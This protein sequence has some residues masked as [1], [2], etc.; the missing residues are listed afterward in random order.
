MLKHSKIGVRLFLLFLLTAVVPVIS[1]IIYFGSELEKISLQQ[2]EKQLVFDAKNFSEAILNKLKSADTSLYQLE[3]ELIARGLSN[4]DLNTIREIFSAISISRDQK[5]LAVFYGDAISFS[6]LKIKT[7]GTRITSFS[8]NGVEHIALIHANTTN[9]IT[10]VGIIN[11]NFLWLNEVANDNTNYTIYG[12]GQRLATLARDDQ[13]GEVMLLN[14]SSPTKVKRSIKSNVDSMSRSRDIN[15]SSLFD[16]EPW[17]VTATLGN[18]HNTIASAKS[19]QALTIITFSILLLV[20]LISSRQIR[21]IVSPLEKLTSATQRLGTNNSHEPLIIDS[22]D[23]IGQLAQSFNKMSEKLVKQFRTLEGLSIIDE[24]ILT[25]ENIRNTS[26]LILREICEIFNCQQSMLLIIPENKNESAQT[27][28]YDTSVAGVAKHR[29]QKSTALEDHTLP[30]DSNTTYYRNGTEFP[31]IFK[32][33]S[34][35]GVNQLLVSPVVSDSKLIA[36]IAAGFASQQDDIESLISSLE[37]FSRRVGVA[38]RSTQDSQK[39]YHRANY[40]SLTGLS[41]RAHFIEQLNAIIQ[42]ANAE[43][44]SLA[45]MFIDLDRFKHVNDVQ[46]HE[47]GDKL[48]KHVAEKL[49]KATNDDSIVARFG[50]D[51]FLILMPETSSQKYV[52]IM[53][54]AL[55]NDLSQPITID[56]HEHFIDSSIGIAMYP[57]HGK[58]AEILIKNTDIAMYLAKQAGGGNYRVFN[59]QMNANAMKRVALESALYHAIER[60]ELFLVYQPKMCIKK[61]R[62]CGAEALIRWQHPIHG[63]IPPDQFVAIAEETG[64][65]LPIGTWIYRSIIKQIASW[66]KQGLT[67]DHIAINISVR[68][69]KSEGF[70]EKLRMCLEEHKVEPKYIDIEITETMFID[71]MENSIKVL[72]QLHE[73]GVSISID[74]FG[75]GYSSLNYLSQLPFDTLKIDRS[76]LEKVNQDKNAASLTSAIIA[77]AHS[78]DKNVVAEGVE[79]LE[80]LQFLR[81]RDCDYAQG[82]Y[83]AKPLSSSDFEHYSKAHAEKTDISAHALNH[84]QQ[85]Q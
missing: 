17:Q 5:K 56:F 7:V 47:A 16:A 21:K 66:L 62:I 75:T 45:L 83:Y 27:L 71:D 58:S 72:E 28:R 60:D 13:S 80:Q 41:N 30:S 61:D 2:F 12:N 50:G 77:L 25:G 11:P 34:E 67:L 37:N 64:Q 53:A 24:S 44:T 73:L 6:H 3:Q 9:N 82:F 81:D 18:K 59:N 52:E 69:I 14:A 20:A 76:F 68:Q 39:L 51:E 55:I 79:T 35:I 19:G 22:N 85:S 26:E 49:R 46:G 84:V 74:D 33:L 32:Q 29:L 8:V 70:V 4:I 63:M 40:D 36:Y 78:L 65:I 43:G 57:E 10:L 23:E 48:L 38:I 1:A 31:R 54:K 15:L 42:C